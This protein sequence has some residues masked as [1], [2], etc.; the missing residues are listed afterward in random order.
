MW[1]PSISPQESVIWQIGKPHAWPG[2]SRVSNR[3]S[4]SYNSIS[5]TPR[6]VTAV[7]QATWIFKRSQ[8]NP[9]EFVCTFSIYLLLIAE[10]PNAQFDLEICQFHSL[11]LKL[12]QVSRLILK[13]CLP[14]WLLRVCA[15]LCVNFT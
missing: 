1:S 8:P 6:V 4:T 11:S 10:K 7:A 15:N 12:L 2:Q 14:C 9:C 13:R 3:T 5:L